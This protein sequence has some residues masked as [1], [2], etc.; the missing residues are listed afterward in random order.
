MEGGI[1]ENSL[2]KTKD[3]RL[4]VWRRK[5][6]RHLP[7]TRWLPLYKKEDLLSDLIAG[8]TLGL[9]MVPQSIAYA[10]LAG[11]TSQYGLYSTF[12]GGYVYFFLGTIKEVSVGP[13]SL[14]ALLTFEFSKEL[15]FEF[16][17]LLTFMSGCV[18][19][20]MGIFQFG[21]LVD[22]ISA[23]VISG[24]QSA[25]SV[26][27]ITSQLKGILG[28]RKVKSGRFLE[29][30]MNVIY[31]LPETRFSDVTLGICCCIVLLL[32]RRLKDI[33]LGKMTEKKMKIKKCLWF[34]SISRN[35]IVVLVCGCI[36][37]YFHEN[38]STPFLLSGK[39]PEGLPPFR[40]PRF[41][42]EFGNRT[43][44]FTEMCYEIGSGIFILPLVSVLA[45][46]TIAKAFST[47]GSV[48][49]T[50]EMFT[51][52]M[53]NILGSFVS[54]MP[55]CGAFTRSAVSN[56]SGVRTPMSGLFS[57][58]LILIFLVFFS[59]Y[60]YYIPRA[61]LSA[62]LICAVIFMIDWKTCFLLWKAN[63]KRDLVCFLGTCTACLALGVEI[64][65]LVGVA[66]N[67]AQLMYLWARPSI[68]I[69]VKETKGG[70]YY[71]IKPDIGLFFPA[72]DF[73]RN[74]INKK[75]PGE[76]PFRA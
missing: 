53:C 28:L 41:S 1:M 61:S 37:Y 32:L 46:V 35:A 38:E 44:S 68:S 16:V 3:K 21:F 6:Y 43:Y 24:F 18:E 50:Q 19:L 33:K 36:A 57:G 70:F 26:I 31:K 54:S 11:L 4:P 75:C 47:G 30:I 63:N 13:T 71:Y 17:C 2:D 72:V 39:I 64:G 74:E 20:L 66:I 22:F 45:N 29:N 52:G 49:A 48:D 73:L 76:I 8:L 51:L 69:E 59:P 7:I 9:T 34:V 10:A 42:T 23:P 5:L 15:P 14:M 58:S 67:I 65:L 56:S 62:V 12:M 25:T 60:L 55:T 40:L 27:I